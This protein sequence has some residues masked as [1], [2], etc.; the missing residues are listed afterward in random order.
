[1]VFENLKIV[2]KSINIFC[3]GVAPNCI[4]Q[5]LL[6][7]AFWGLKIGTE[8][9]VLIYYVR[10]FWGLPYG[11]VNQIFQDVEQNFQMQF[12]KPGNKK[13]TLLPP[14][15]RALIA[16]HAAMEDVLWRYEELQCPETN[17]I[18]SERLKEKDV[19][20]PNHPRSNYGKLMERILTLREKK[21]PIFQDLIPHAKQR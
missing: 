9:L 11:D 13:S 6:Q 5:I 2:L 12:R 17:Q 19:F 14:K 15:A 10:L 1:M 20:N 18:L 8:C 4:L 21:I 16:R 7:N 3:R